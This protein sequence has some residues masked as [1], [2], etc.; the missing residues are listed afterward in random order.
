MKENVELVKRKRSSV[1]EGEN[2]KKEEKEKNESD[3][4]ES[5]REIPFRLSEVGSVGFFGATGRWLTTPN[6]TEQPRENRFN[7]PTQSLM[8][9]ESY[10]GNQSL[11]KEEY[12]R[13]SCIS[14]WQRVR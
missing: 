13:L 7:S 1:V 12:A 2:K 9:N 10:K 3:D 5:K 6:G 8:V 14:A 11:H 4:E